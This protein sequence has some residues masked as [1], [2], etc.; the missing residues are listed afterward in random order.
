MLLICDWIHSLK[1]LSTRRNK[2]FQKF[3]HQEC[4]KR[5]W[6]K[7][8]FQTSNFLLNSSVLSVTLHICDKTPW[9]PASDKVKCFPNMNVGAHYPRDIMLKTSVYWGIHLVFSRRAWSIV[10]V[11][12]TMEGTVRNAYFFASILQT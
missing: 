11:L 12:T 10:V 2:E 7:L 5:E 1:K 3:F 6:E 8:L 9:L 4:L